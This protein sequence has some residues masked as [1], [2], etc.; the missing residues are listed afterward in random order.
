MSGGQRS[1]TGPSGSGI[2][3]RVRAAVSIVI[4]A[5]YA[6]L[7][8]ELLVAVP[9]LAAILNGAQVAPSVLKA[10]SLT[11]LA[12]VAPLVILALTAVFGRFYCSSLCPLGALQDLALF[13]ARR[14]G[15][16][17]RFRSQRSLSVLHYSVLAAVAAA[18]VAGNVFLL[19]VLEPFALFGRFMTDVFRQGLDV[20]ANGLYELLRMAGIRPAARVSRVPAGWVAALAAAA[21]LAGLLVL[22][23]LR[24]RKFCN[25][26]CPT[27]ALF[28]LLSRFSVF[29]IRLDPS[30]CVSCGLC[31]SVCRAGCI[32][33][34]RRTVDHTRC[35]LCFDCVAV[36]RESGLVYASAKRVKT[37]ANGGSRKEFLRMTAAAL[38]TLPVAGGIL[39]AAGTGRITRR[40]PVIPPGSRDRETFLANCIACHQ[41]VASCPNRIIR[42]SVFEFGF[43]GLFQPVLDYS[44]HFCSFECNACTQVCP[45]GAIRPLTL[46]EKKLTRIGL[47]RLDKKRCIVYDK[48]LDCGACAEHCP[49]KAVHLVDWNGLGAPETD[50]TL[51]IGCGACEYICPV[52]PKA[53]VVEGLAVHEQAKPR[54]DGRLKR[55]AGKEDFPF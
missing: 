51:C 24:G 3:G 53:I 20:L 13:A 7:F 8:L 46:P 5:L 30:R 17:R 52:R 9:V 1:R 49:N 11:V 33:A 43:A 16:A 36:C 12:G 6:A 19:T 47:S 41:C 28:R 10:F 25:T 4:G 22:T 42:P 29:R 15:L 35:V 45:T 50:D 18:L 23:A 26:L 37:D 14:A 31:E 54:S 2:P 32:D 34:K 44:L 48:K 27:G 40:S 39:H 38:L 55:P 21:G